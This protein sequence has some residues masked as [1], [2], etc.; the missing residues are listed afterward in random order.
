MKK[1]NVRIKKNITL[2]DRVNAIEGIVSACFTGGKYTPYYR[3]M[4]E[5]LA[6]ITCFIDGLEFEENEAIYTSA[7]SDPEV[8]NLIDLFKQPRM[9]VYENLEYVREYVDDI[10]EFEKQRLIH[11][12]ADTD[13]IVEACNVIIDSLDNFSKLNVEQMSKEDMNVA[14]N[15]MKQL[16]EKNFTKEDL[17]EILKNASN[18]NMDE[19]TKEIIDTKNTEIREL[20]K[21]KTL[22]ESRNVTNEN[23][24][25]EMPT[26]E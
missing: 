9:E 26:K 20:K 8:R 11:S 1:D 18:F 17:T 5:T 7:I 14:M 13:K 21:Y 4:A 10:L 6:I 12:H 2:M 24:I 15:V 25:V 19:A 23:K 22:W 16:S 3:D